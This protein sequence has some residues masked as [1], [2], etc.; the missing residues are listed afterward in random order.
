MRWCDAVSEETSLQESGIS[1]E[2]AVVTAQDRNQWRSFVLALC[3][4]SP[5]QQL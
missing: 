1:F 2:E 5:Q 3:G 4:H